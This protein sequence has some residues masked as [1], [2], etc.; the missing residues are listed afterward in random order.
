V[1]VRRAPFPAALA[2]ADALRRDPRLLPHHAPAHR[3]RVTNPRL[4]AFNTTRHGSKSRP[5]HAGRLSFIDSSHRICIASCSCVSSTPSRI[6][7]LPYPPAVTLVALRSSPAAWLPGRCSTACRYRSL[8]SLCIWCSPII[9]NPLR[10]LLGD[11]DNQRSDAAS[12]MR[13]FLHTATCGSL[14]CREVTWK[15]PDFSFHPPDLPNAL[16]QRHPYYRRPS[17]LFG[18]YV[19]DSFVRPL[20]LLH[21]MT[22]GPPTPIKRLSSVGDHASSVHQNQLYSCTVI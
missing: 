11:K 7:Y 13:R 16:Y 1:S 3:A 2:R 18:L 14:P 4:S 21:S 12:E 6:L 5:H 19:S 20:S 22:V 10:S 15:N 8:W 17:P 9:R